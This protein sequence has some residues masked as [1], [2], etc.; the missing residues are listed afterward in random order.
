MAETEEIT[1]VCMLAGKLMLEN[2]AE[3]HRV[4]D[5]MIRIGEA[6]GLEN[7]QSFATPTGINFSV[8]Y[9][10]AISF[11][12]I[13]NRTTDLH[14]I[15]LVNNVSRKIVEK[16][17]NL[18]EAMQEL[19]SIEDI[20]TFFPS[21]VQIVAASL[22]SGCFLIMFG[23]LWSDFIP[24]M[25]T[26]G[27]G[28]AG[29]VAVNRLVNIRFVAD[30]FGALLIGIFAIYFVKTGMGVNLDKLIIGSVMPLVPGLPITNAVRELLSGHLIAGVSKGVEAQLAALA[31]GA[32]I[33]VV[34]SLT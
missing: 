25:I 8:G 24:T 18:Q 30:F 4:E 15:Y 12:R 13:S 11:M 5:T 21:W 3:T 33:A 19:Q 14:K 32:G 23:G 26:G 22:A 6:F 10:E 16:Q 31:I 29:M 7:I 28:F 34:L 17:L 1:K 20:D 9:V 27:I 2:G